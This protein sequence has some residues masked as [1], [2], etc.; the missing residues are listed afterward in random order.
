V[1]QRVAQSTL[2][3]RLG[4]A[5]LVVAMSL[6]GSAAADTGD[7]SGLSL[8][9][10]IVKPALTV[11]VIY[12]SNVFRQQTSPQADLGV[13]AVPSL[14]LIFP[15]ESFR[16]EL[17]AYY[18]FFTYF[19]VAGKNH[20]VLRD[21]ANFSIGTSFDVNRKGK[22]GFWFAPS[23]FNRRG[24]RGADTEPSQGSD[25]GYELGVNV[26]LE[27]RIRPTQAFQFKIDA[28]WQYI[29]AYFTQA[30][31]D[32]NPEVLGQPHDVGGGLSIDWKFFPRSHFLF[33]GDV[34]H[35]FQ[36][37]YDEASALHDAPIEN[38]YFRLL[39]GMKGDVTRKLSMMGMIGYGG[40][41]LG[42]ANRDDNLTGID[43]LIGR[44]EIAIRPLLTQR[45]AFGFSRDFYF[46]YY[47]FH[48]TDMQAYVKYKGLIAERLA[49]LASFSYTFRDLEGI[50]G[51][52]D[53]I[54]RT[55]NQWGA[56]VGVEITVAE[57]FHILAG[58]KFS[59]VNPSS[60]SIGEYIDN[61]VNIGVTLGFR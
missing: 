3:T 11:E 48:I 49:I 12:D 32:S 1:A 13:Q 58:Y 45:I 54:P 42:E 55:E 57:W 8:G 34:G 5:L 33:D 27:F 26:P 44:A 59:A 14:Q 47:A 2:A 61:R 9:Q 18:R 52:S 30:T 24:L 36:G 10:L 39:V 56:G 15:G 40:V 46:K 37:P 31:F 35:V 21:L 41:F 51:G 7:D 60:N 16:W 20:D 50:E 6:A 19:N 23:F 25:L 53:G 29:R 43:G 17:D 22:F 28:H 4:V 38:T